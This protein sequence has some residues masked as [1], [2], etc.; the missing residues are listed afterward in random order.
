MVHTFVNVIVLDSTKVKEIGYD[1]YEDFNYVTEQ[2]IFGKEIY[3]LYHDNKKHLLL[4]CQN[5]DFST[6]IDGK[7]DTFDRYLQHKN[8]RHDLKDYKR[9]GCIID[10]WFLN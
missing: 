2:E 8:N 7:L 3:L 9:N 6:Y 10:E 4:K 5:D 1:P